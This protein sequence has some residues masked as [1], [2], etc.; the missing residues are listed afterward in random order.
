MQTIVEVGI[1]LD[2][3]LQ[4][5]Q[6]LLSK[7]GAENVFYTE[8]HDKYWTNKKFDELAEMSENQIKMSCIRV[9]G[10]G[11][12]FSETDESLLKNIK[13]SVENSNLFNY[14]NSDHEKLSKKKLDKFIDE[15]EKDG[16]YL[17]FDTFKVDYHYQ[18]NGMKS[19]IQIQE[20]DD[21][22]LVLYYDNPDYYDM[23]EQLQWKSLIDELNS[24]GF[25]FQYNEPGI[26][27]LRTLLFGYGQY[28]FNQNG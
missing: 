18:I 1:L 5:Y 3:D 9:R 27:K 8:T 19:R 12:N 6:E 26:D 10:N 21:I 16:W 25:D 24:Y 20:I 17:I 22:G 4:Y 11:L 13:F 15:I 2:K 7:A 28:S 14:K 23:P